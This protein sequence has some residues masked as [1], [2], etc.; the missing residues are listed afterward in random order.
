MNKSLADRLR[1]A[2]FACHSLSLGFR[3]NNTRDKAL[4]RLALPHRNTFPP[5]SPTLPVSTDPT[6]KNVLIWLLKQDANKYCIVSV[7]FLFTPSVH[8]LDTNRSAAQTSFLITMKLHPQQINTTAASQILPIF[9]QP[10]H[11][12]QFLHDAF[13]IIKSGFKEASTHSAEK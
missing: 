12:L 9:S 5:L 4:M 11:L 6:Y 13:L 7:S 1:P 8:S 2:S 3:D 10:V